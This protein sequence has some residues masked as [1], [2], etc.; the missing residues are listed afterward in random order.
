[1]ISKVAMPE[2]KTIEPFVSASPADEIS[3]CGDHCVVLVQIPT[4]L[5]CL[6]IIDPGEFI[7]VYRICM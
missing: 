4:A 1:M 5:A 2:K 6:C 3:R 7:K